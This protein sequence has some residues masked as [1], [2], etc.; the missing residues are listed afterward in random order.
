MIL[1][2]RLEAKYSKDEVLALYASNAPMG[3][4]IVGLDAASWRYFGRDAHEL[5]W[6]EVSMLAV[7]P[8]APSLI[9]LGKNRGKLFAKRNRLLLCPA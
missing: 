2:T 1:A 3:G 4:N 8:N 9:H 7:L 5:S 6:A